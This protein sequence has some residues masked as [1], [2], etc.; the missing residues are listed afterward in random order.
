MFSRAG[1]DA[2]EALVSAIVAAGLAGE[3]DRKGLHAVKEDAQRELAVDFPEVN[4]TEP[5]GMI[6]HQ[7]NE[8]LCKPQMWQE[9]GRWTG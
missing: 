7:L 8:R 3:L 2:C 4:D 5:D 1:N 6:C 9:Y